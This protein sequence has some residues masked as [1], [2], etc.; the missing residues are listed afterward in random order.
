MRHKKKRADKYTT[1]LAQCRDEYD[2]MTSKAERRTLLKSVLDELFG[3]LGQSILR[4]KAA[5]ERI[6]RGVARHNE[7]CKLLAEVQTS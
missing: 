3:P 7:L 2:V 4:K 5:K 6:V 1:A